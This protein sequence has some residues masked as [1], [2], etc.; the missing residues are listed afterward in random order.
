[1]AGSRNTVHR[2]SINTVNVAS[3]QWKKTQTT[4]QHSKPPKESAACYN[5]PATIRKEV[6]EEECQNVSALQHKR[7]IFLQENRLQETHLLKLQRCR[8]HN[9]FSNNKVDNSVKRNFRNPIQSFC[10]QLMLMLGPGVLFVCSLLQHSVYYT[11]ERRV[12]L[13]DCFQ[14]PGS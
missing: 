14:N 10:F 6:S 3:C 8:F 5:L 11:V 1:M 12:V 9:L 13:T 7:T 4:F 2:Q